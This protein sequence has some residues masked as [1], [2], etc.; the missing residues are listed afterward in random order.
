MGKTIKYPHNFSESHYLYQ[1]FRMNNK[2]YHNN[3]NKNSIEITGLK[4]GKVIFYFA[5]KNAESESGNLPG[6]IEAYDTLENSGVTHVSD[7]GI[8]KIYLEC[9][10]LYYQPND[11]KI[12]PRHFHFVYWK[13]DKWDLKTFT[14][15]KIFCDINLKNKD[16]T[17]FIIIDALPKKYYDE[18]H[19]KGAIS[20][21]Y[22]KKY[23]EKDV[24]IFKNNKA[25]ILYCWSDDCDAAHK[26]K[27]KF[28]KLGIYNTWHLKGGIS[29]WKGPTE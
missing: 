2:S 13:N 9:P 15:H 10:S 29:K 19:I 3:A 11:N 28:D 23:T 20:M 14:T 27:D 17:H 8:A 12:Y 24:E 16:L 1:F 7:K 25:I 26:L 6:L 18:R 22:N 4:P 5:A 21:P